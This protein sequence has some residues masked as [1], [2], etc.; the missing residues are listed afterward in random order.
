MPYGAQLLPGGYSNTTH[1][2]GVKRGVGYAVGFKNIGYSEGFDDYS[3]AR[4]RLF[5][6]H[7]KP[8]VEVHTAAAEVGQGVALVQ[9]QVAGSELGV[10]DVVVLNA[11]TRVG[12]A[13][14]SSASRQTYITGGAVKAASE[15]VCRR[16]LDLA[17]SELR[18]ASGL[19]IENDAV[20]DAVGNQVIALATLLGDAVIDET[21][22]FRPRRTNHLD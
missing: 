3:T 20:V 18:P 1:G 7:G 17:E 16:V 14:S 12:S 6:H 19:R 15:A 2:E 22:E 10:T 21:R 5:V 13:G 8:R 9:A 11:D 4:V